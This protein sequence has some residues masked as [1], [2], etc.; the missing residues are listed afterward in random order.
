MK[1]SARLLMLSAL[2][3]SIILSSYFFWRVWQNN[4]GTDTPSHAEIKQHFEQSVNWLK[5]NYNDVENIRN[6]I[7]WWMIKQA[8]TNS[9]DKTLNDI[10]INYKKTHLDTRP[11]NFSTPMFDKFYR[12]RMPGIEQFSKLH[13]YQTFFFYALSCDKDLSSEPVIQQQMN[14]GFCSM[15]YL[16][17]RCITHQVMG[18]R[19]MQR[20]QC[21]YDERV[22]STIASLQQDINSELTWDFRVGDAYIQRVLM[23]VDSGAYNRVKP[24]WISHVLNA[25]NEDGSWDDL[26][27]VLN[28]GNNKAF[29]FTSMLPKIKTIK[30]DFHATAQGIWL[31]SLLLEETRKD[32]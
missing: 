22:S 8:A 15:H 32:Q 14:P 27:P 21:G 26:D 25:Q 2:I 4:I 17:P 20:Y 29:G 6:P 12:P 13:P 24:V 11:P 18:L 16:H 3:F 31:L 28:L 9:N 1:Q 23:L 10:F 19:F 5:L 7:L 30:A